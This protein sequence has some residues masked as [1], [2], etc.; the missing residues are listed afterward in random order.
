MA[1]LLLAALLILP[2]FGRPALRRCGQLIRGARWLLLSVFVILAWGGAGDPAWADRWR[3][4]AR[5]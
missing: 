1:S 4:V 2:F 3:P 5:G